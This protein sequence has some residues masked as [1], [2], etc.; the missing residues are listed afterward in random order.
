M[1]SH[2]ITLCLSDGNDER[3]IDVGII[4]RKGFEIESM[5]SHVDDI[6]S[7][8][9]IFSRG[10]PRISFNYSLG[11]DRFFINKSF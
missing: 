1:G 7:D 11:N 6:D 3:G 8:G 4:S 5:T 10:C 9:L 2:T